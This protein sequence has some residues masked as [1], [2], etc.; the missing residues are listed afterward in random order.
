MTHDRKRRRVGPS[1]IAGV[2]LVDLEVFKPFGQKLR[3]PLA[4]ES[5]AG[6]FMALYSVLIVQRGFRVTDNNESCQRV[7]ASAAKQ[8]TAV[9]LRNEV[10]KDLVF[11]FFAS[12]RMTDPR[13]FGANAPQDDVN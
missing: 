7:I 8:S 4:L 9:I 5:K 1:Q 2:N 13:P 3:L 11:R 12:L 10:T 6:I